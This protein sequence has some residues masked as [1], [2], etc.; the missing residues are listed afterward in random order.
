[1]HAFLDKRYS[2]YIFAPVGS[3]NLLAI[4]TIINRE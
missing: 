3:A 4:S 2:D 1:M